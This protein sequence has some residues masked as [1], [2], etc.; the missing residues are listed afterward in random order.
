MTKIII[1]TDRWITP[2]K[3]AELTGLSQSA[4]TKI[5]AEDRAN[6]KIHPEIGVKLIEHPKFAKPKK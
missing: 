6:V 1:D 3:Y 2:K 5:M 4:V